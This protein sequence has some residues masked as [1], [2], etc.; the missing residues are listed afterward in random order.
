MFVV[1]RDE[2]YFFEPIGS[3]MALFVDQVELSIGGYS[4]DASGESTGQVSEPM[5]ALFTEKGASIVCL[6]LS[7]QALTQGFVC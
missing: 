3:A 4:V 7:R 6:E 1:L 5:K 2:F